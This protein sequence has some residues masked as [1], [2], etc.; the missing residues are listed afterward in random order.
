MT[1]TSELPVRTS[2]RAVTLQRW[3]T[4]SRHLLTRVL[5]GLRALD[6]PD[7]CRSQETPHGYSHAHL[8]AD[9]HARHRCP[10][11]QLAIAYRQA[12]RP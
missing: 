1:E 3:H 11:Y 12:A 7:A 6:Y 2:Y 9:R 5:A 10:R 8:I 4:N